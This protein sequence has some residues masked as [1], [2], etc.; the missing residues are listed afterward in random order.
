MSTTSILAVCV[1]LALTVVLPVGA[2][3]L[4]GRRGGKWRCFFAGA[5][6]FILFAM[7]LEQLL[8]S[9]VLR[10]PA[11]AVLQGNIWLYGLYGGL[12]AGLFEETGRLAAFRLL[13]KK[14]TRPVTAL[15]Y[16]LGHGGIEAM[17]ITGM[18]MVN[19]MIVAAAVSGGRELAPELESA[20]AVLAATPATLFLWAGFER[21]VAI[22][23]HVANSVLVF[24]AVRRQRYGLYL[25]AILTHTAVNFLAV[26]TNAYCSVAITELAVLAFTALV[27]LA[28]ARVYRGL[29]EEGE[30]LC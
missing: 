2:M 19:N 4:L 7:I 16:G 3:L 20:A 10:S 12:A 28:A 17:L 8:H 6:A 13:L 15:A 18:T 23:L 1:T 30:H 27:A 26:V 9:A 21:V 5:A 14:E 25:A 29:T 22:A 11:G 24:A